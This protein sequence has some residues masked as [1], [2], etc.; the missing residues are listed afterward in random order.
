MVLDTNWKRIDRQLIWRSLS[1]SYW[2][3]LE[4][5]FACAF[6]PLLLC[7]NCGVLF[8]FHS[9]FISKEVGW[10]A[11]IEFDCN[12]NWNAW[13]TDSLPLAIFIFD[14]LGWKKFF[15]QFKKM[16]SNLYSDRICGCRCGKQSPFYVVI[17]GQK[18]KIF[19]LVS[20]LSF[21]EDTGIRGS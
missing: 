4:Y 20:N 13:K 7:L 14:G 18:F 12:L 10:F 9:V 17:L 11:E 21:L 15:L 2:L 6:L 16:I 1:D 19:K 5:V 3:S 8:F